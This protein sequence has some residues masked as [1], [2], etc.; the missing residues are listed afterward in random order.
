M[1]TEEVRKQARREKARSHFAWQEHVAARKDLSA[2]VK[3]VALRLALF[4]NVQSGRCDPSIAGLGDG[5]NL[6]RST[7][8]RAIK[9][10][11]ALNLIVVEHA[12]GGSGH[13]NRYH[14][15]LPLTGTEWVHRCEPQRKSEKGPSQ[16]CA[17][18]HFEQE[19]GP[20]E[21]RNRSK[22]S[23]KRVH[24]P[25]PRTW[26]HE[27]PKEGGEHVEHASA[28]PS[29]APADAAAPGAPRKARQE[30]K[31]GSGKVRP[32]ESSKPGPQ[33]RQIRQ[34]TTPGRPLALTQSDGWQAQSIQQMLA[35]EKPHAELERGYDYEIHDAAD[36][37]DDFKPV[38]WAQWSGSRWQCRQVADEELAPLGFWQCEPGCRRHERYDY[39]EWLEDQ[40]ELDEDP[41][42]HG[43]DFHLVDDDD[44][45]RAVARWNGW[46]Y[47]VT[48]VSHRRKN[49]KPTAH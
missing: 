19:T 8:K 15:L 12:P 26:K 29:A 30:S 45:L 39:A 42:D 28:A 49:K 34:L 38:T 10:L 21:A 32:A 47:N 16:T 22:S 33:G 2:G 9:R 18:V 13:R 6:S 36:T 37:H 24:S 43:H 1:D 31:D 4:C 20:T 5:S 11:E 14:L 41:S 46:R 40:A 35:G 48:E 3:V 7:V 27:P 44:T 25:E 23:E 17:E